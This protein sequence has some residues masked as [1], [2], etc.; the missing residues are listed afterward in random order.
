MTSAD[1]AY[2]SMYLIGFIIMMVHTVLRC[3]KYGI[4][5]PRSVI[6]T[7]LTYIYGVGGAIIMGNIYSSAAAARGSG[8]ISKVAI[9]GAVIF[10]PIFL[11][12]SVIL[13]NL[14]RR[15]L[16]KDQVSLRNTLDLLTPGIFIILTCAKFGCALIGCCHG[17]GCTFGV[18]HPDLHM[19][20]FPV[21]ICEVVCMMLIIYLVS[22]LESKGK[23]RPGMKYFVTAGLYSVCRFFWEFFRYYDS[24][25]MRNFCLGMTMWQACCLMVLLVSVIMILALHSYSGT[26]KKKLPEPRLHRKKRK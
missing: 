19:Y 25:L 22:I 21:Q 7:L 15:L 26:E 20:V 14:G 23:L 1:K 9:F 13:E 10:A 6:Y 17:I 11:I 16:K 18:Y 3:K 5:R 4:S 24:P 8:D 2:Y 12:I